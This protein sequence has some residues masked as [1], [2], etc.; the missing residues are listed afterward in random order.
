MARRG[1]GEREREPDAISRKL[2]DCATPTLRSMLAAFFTPP[3]VSQSKKTVMSLFRLVPASRAPRDAPRPLAAD[4]PRKFRTALAFR[5][6][7]AFFLAATPFLAHAPLAADAPAAPAV[8]TYARDVAPIF[9]IA[10]EECHRP[11]QI[12]PMSL[13]DY[14][15]VRP[16]A[17]SI[18]RAV[19]DRVMPPWPAAHDGPR[20]AND[21]SLSDADLATILAWIDAGAPL[22]DPADLPPPRDWPAD[23][24]LGPPDSLVAMPQPFAVPADGRDIYRCFVLDP[25]L[26]SDRWA[27]AVEVL[28]GDFAVAHHVVLYVDKRDASAP[29]DAADPAPGYDCF[30]GPGFMASMLGGWG[31]GMDPKVYPPDTGHLV[32]AGTKIVMQ[33]HYHPSGEPRAD[34]TRVGLH[35]ADAPPSRPLA[36]GLVLQFDLNI[37]AGDPAHVAAAD[38]R[39]MRPVLVHSVQPHMHLLGKS[40]EMWA[41]LPDG[42]RID[43]VRI[44]R[45]DFHWQMEYIFAEPVRL[46]ARSTVH[47]RGVF[48]NS[49][50][51]PAQPVHPPRNVRFG[52]ETTD[53]MLVGVYNYTEEPRDSAA[54][55]HDDAAKVHADATRVHP[56][57]QPVQA[58]PVPVRAYAEPVQAYAD[59]VHVYAEPVHVYT[60]RVHAYAEPVH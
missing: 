49:A 9:R 3:P 6:V 58:Y 25:G 19:A 57:P 26:A 53:E 1:S 36:D 48:D 24:E 18:R 35:F 11:G 27:S 20:F 4:P 22:G 2:R 23:W 31:P 41:T 44:P 51:N 52:E 60:Q 15:S 56:S 12:A 43:L 39:V 16:W 40:V 5:V 47:I 38:R 33:M 37:P 7:R 32:P 8:P 10:C 34:L 21:R 54:S 14:D 45:W 46:P 59:R 28:P 29:L 50:E 17:K 13:L 42:A 30:G 55:V